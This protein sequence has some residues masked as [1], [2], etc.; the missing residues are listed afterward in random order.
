MDEY[1]KIASAQKRDIN[2]KLDKL[3]ERIDEAANAIPEL[4][5]ND[6]AAK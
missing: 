5:V 6:K 1:R 3:P 4:W 2:N